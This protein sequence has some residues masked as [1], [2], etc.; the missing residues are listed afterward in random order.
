MERQR[1]YDCG[2]EVSGHVDAIGRHNRA[3]I[4][5]QIEYKNRL[6]IPY[7]PYA[8]NLRHVHSDVDHFPYTRFYRG[9]FNDTRPHIWDRE[10]GYHRLQDGAYDAHLLYVQNPH[11][12]P[13]QIPCTTV[14]RKHMPCR[15]PLCPPKAC[16][17]SSP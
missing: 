6:S 10:A 8:S 11:Q 7:T 1:M 4:Q 13:T 17:D 5:Q 14:L 9:Q 16:V 12:S 3:L 2:L 15:D